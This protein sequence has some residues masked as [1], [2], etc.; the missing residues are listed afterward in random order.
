MAYR[1][2]V[3]EKLDGGKKF[4]VTF[5]NDVDHT[6]DK[7]IVPADEQGLIYAIKGELH[8][9]NSTPALDQKYDAGSVIDL[10][11]G[12]VTTPATPETVYQTARYDLINAE[13]DLRLGLIDEKEFN[14]MKSKTL[15]LKPARK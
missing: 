8:R 12:P 7:E 4:I 14:V 1:H 10:N 5:T 15:A 9:L 13:T 2:F 6:F 11:D 3:K